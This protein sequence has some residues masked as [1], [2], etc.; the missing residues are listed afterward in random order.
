MSY[1]V[2]YWCKACEFFEEVQMLPDEK[3]ESCGCP[4]H[5]HVCAKVVDA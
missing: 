5:N 1:A 4:L 2:G 3:C